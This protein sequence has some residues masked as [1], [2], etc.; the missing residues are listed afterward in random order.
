MEKIW[1]IWPFF[2][3]KDNQNVPTSRWPRYWTYQ[4]IEN[5]ECNYAPE[6]RK[7]HL[8]L[9]DKNAKHINCKKEQTEIIEMKNTI[10]GKKTYSVG[11]RAGSSA[12]SI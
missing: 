10:Y 9:Q 4:R 8:K 3:G 1:K 11:S 12:K 5:I 2:K 7:T 6:G